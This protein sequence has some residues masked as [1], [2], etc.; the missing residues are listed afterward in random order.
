MGDRPRRASVAEGRV[1]IGFFSGLDT[2]ASVN[3]IPAV[4]VHSL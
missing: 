4:G 2:C 3:R 1:K